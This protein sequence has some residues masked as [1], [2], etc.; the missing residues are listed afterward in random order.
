MVE[1]FP[2]HGGK[3]EKMWILLEMI[4]GERFLGGG[5]RRLVKKICTEKLTQCSW[6]IQSIFYLPKKLSTEP[7]KKE[8]VIEEKN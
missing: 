3:A 6:D 5:A 2:S 7:K 4:K 1:F 8:V